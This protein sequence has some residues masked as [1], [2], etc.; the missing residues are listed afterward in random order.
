MDRH[1]VTETLDDFPKQNKT[2]HIE[3][4]LITSNGKL[5]K[6]IH[7][8]NSTNNMQ[9][10]ST[11]NNNRNN[12]NHTNERMNNEQK[13]SVNNIPLH[14]NIEEHNEKVTLR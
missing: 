2:K 4:K 8:G 14:K 6:N 3:K 12:V 10:E 11:S 1:T 9:Q 5:K 7:T 13:D